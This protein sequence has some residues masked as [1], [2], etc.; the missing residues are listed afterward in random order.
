MG[1]PMPQEGDS[2]IIVSLSEAAMHMYTAA[3]DALPFAEDRKFHKR[4]DVVLEGMRK[5]RAALADAAS[6]ARPSAA[7]IVELS[8]VR[9]RYDA[10]MEHA[11]AAPGSRLGQQ[12]YV[13]RVHAKLTAQEVANGAGLRADLLDELETGGTPTD[14][15]AAKIR[16]AIAALG[17]VPGTEHLQYHEPEQPQHEEH[18]EPVESHVNGWDE[19]LVGDNAG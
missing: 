15:E 14:E 12:M 6:T 2:S 16:E 13:T 19:S 18:E 17:G 7:V 11:A 3:I 4:A 8:N 10:L 9:R 5:L 1:Q